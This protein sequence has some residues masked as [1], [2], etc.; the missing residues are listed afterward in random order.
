M[1]GTYG[2]STI[3]KKPED[4]TKILENIRKL[5]TNK[6][7]FDCGEK[8]LHSFYL[9]GNY[10]FS[11]AIWNICLFKMR[12]NSQGIKYKSEGNRSL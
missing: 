2:S 8:V 9:I 7:C 6:E 1:K 12:W 11:N 5:G 3:A 4:N 10:L